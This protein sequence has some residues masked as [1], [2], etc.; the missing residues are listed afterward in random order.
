MSDTTCQHNSYWKTTFGNCMACRAEKAERELAAEREAREKAEHAIAEANA[1]VVTKE[2]NLGLAQ[3]RADKAEA[4]LN[5]AREAL[6]DVAMHRSED[7]DGNY[8]CWL[9]ETSFLLVQKA[10][11]KIK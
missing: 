7:R 9:G 2:N 4:K 1:S 3:M 5:I 11:D 10:L 8:V 6:E